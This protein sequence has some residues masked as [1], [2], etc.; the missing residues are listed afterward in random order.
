MIDESKDGASP[1]PGATLGDLSS[2][3]HTTRHGGVNE[4]SFVDPKTRYFSPHFSVTGEDCEQSF[5]EPCVDRKAMAVAQSNEYGLQLF[6]E[7]RE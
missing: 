5:P 6:P 7:T 2:I 3:E 4:S 1:R